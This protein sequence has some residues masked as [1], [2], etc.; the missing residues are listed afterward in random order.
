ML[1]TAED[2]TKLTTGEGQLHIACHISVTGTSVDF[3]DDACGHTSHDDVR[4]AI[5]LGIITGAIDI[6]NFQGASATFLADIHRGSDTYITLGVTTTIDCMDLTANQLGQSRTGA[7]NAVSMVSCVCCL[8]NDTYIG[9]RVT[10]ARAITTAKQ[11]FDLVA[12]VHRHICGGHRGSI[13]TAIDSLDTGQV[14]TVNDDLRLVRCRIN[15]I[16]GRLV[17]AAIDGSDVITPF[18][19]RYCCTSIS[20]LIGHM[21]SRRILRTIDMHQH[22]ALRCAVGVVT[23]EDVGHDATCFGSIG[24]SIIV[25]VIQLH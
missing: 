13:T 11:C 9:S 1:I 15:R 21:C 6:S 10:S 3:F 2:T 8:V 24:C 23:T 4:A 22:I 18:L 5:H 19:L 12:T 25:I 7:V 14:A 20:C 16:V 17:A